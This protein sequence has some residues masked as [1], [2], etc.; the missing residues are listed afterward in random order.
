LRFVETLQGPDFIPTWDSLVFKLNGAGIGH[1]WHRD[2][3]PYLAEGVDQEVAAI[4]IGIYLD[5]SDI[6]NCLWVVPGSH[7]WTEDQADQVADSL[8]SGGFDTSRALPIPVSAGDAIIHNIM[9]L[10]GSPASCS[11]LRRVVYLEFRQIEAER[12]FGPHKPEYIPIKQK[13]LRRCILRRRQTSYGAKEQPFVY[14]PQ[15]LPDGI[16][17]PERYRYPHDQYWRYHR[18]FAE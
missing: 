5:Q 1:P 12:A 14:R 2:A 16:D 10:H 18:P 11:K 4:D 9:T 7:R 13:V 6:E 17:L 15:H 8:G 3:A